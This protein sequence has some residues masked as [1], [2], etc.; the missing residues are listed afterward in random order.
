MSVM[1]DARR[2]K[3]QNQSAR[4]NWIA[5]AKDFYARFTEDD[6]PTRAAALAFTGVFS[7]IPLGLVALAI[8]GFLIPD[9]D[10]AM[11]YVENFLS[12]LLP[13]KQGSEAIRD[14]IKQANLAEAA[15]GLMNG[16]FFAAFSG[17]LIQLWAGTGLFVA[18]S[19]PMNAAWDVTETRSFLKLRLTALGIFFGAAALFLLSL[20]PSAGP[21]FVQRLHIPWLGLPQHIPFWIEWLFW[22]AALAVNFAMFILI[23]KFL[24]NA[25]VSWRSAVFGGAVVGVL[26]ELFKRGFA[27]YLSK[28]GN[29][30][31]LYGAF[32]GVALLVT[33]IW[34]S[35]ILLLGG[36]I[37]CKMYEEYRQGRPRKPA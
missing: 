16:S 15:R 26:W 6:C 1:L 22:G 5:L 27:L 30:N 24:P 29:F 35:C 18:A 13:G 20:L 37:I 34:Y 3:K 9:P 19:A 32:G 11:R 23:Y 33:W 8:L 12:Q 21:A 14:L 2:H 28:F 10:Q 7:L 31:K 25:K 36:A 17:V 4:P